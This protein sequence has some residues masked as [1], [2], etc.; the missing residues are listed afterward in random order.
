[1]AFWWCGLLWWAGPLSLVVR[2]R[3]LLV[4]LT[5][6]LCYCV[7][8]ASGKY[9]TF[10]LIGGNDKGLIDVE[11]PPG[12]GTIVDLHSLLAGGYTAFWEIDCPN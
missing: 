4:K 3:R 1:V 7:L 12:S 5:L 11:S 6:G 8:L 9:A 10:R 2:R